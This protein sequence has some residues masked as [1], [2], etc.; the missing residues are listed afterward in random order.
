MDFS[1]FLI[2]Y[3]GTSNKDPRVKLEF[4]FSFYVSITN[5]FYHKKAFKIVF[6]YL[7]NKNKDTDKDNLISFDDFLQG[8]NILHDFGGKCKNE[9]PPVKCAEEIFLGVNKKCDSKLTKE[10]FIEG[11]YL[12]IN[13]I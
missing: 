4:I 8:L 11:I 12:K 5:T 6:I 7:L 10:E 13:L 9:N 1:E 3:S 2:G